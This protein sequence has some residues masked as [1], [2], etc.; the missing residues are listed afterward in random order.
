[1]SSDQW[2]PEQ[3]VRIRMILADGLEVWSSRLKRHEAE[4]CVA[5]G[6]AWLSVHQAQGYQVA[7]AAIVIWTHN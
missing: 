4:R 3:V 7:S 6:S 5:L 2:D 1:M